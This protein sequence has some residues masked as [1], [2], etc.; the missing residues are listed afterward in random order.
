MA[1]PPNLT[2]SQVPTAGQWNSYFSTKQDALGY[3]PVNRAGDTMF[4]KLNILAS[5]TANAG[6]NLAS[7]TPPNSPIDG[8]L[9]TTNTGLFAQIAGNTIGPIRNG[10]V[11]GPNVAVA[12]NIA[13]FADVTGGVIKDSGTSVSALVPTSRQLTAGTGLTGGGSLASD[14]TVGLSSASVASLALAD[15]SLQPS[16]IGT[17]IATAAQ[18]VKADT[19][20]QKAANL[21][22]IASPQAALLNLGIGSYPVKN[23][24]TIIVGDNSAVINAAIVAANAAGGGDVILPPGTTQATAITLLGN[25]NLVPSGGGSTLLNIGTATYF[26]S[27]QGSLGSPVSLTVDAAA[28]AMTLTMASTTGFSVGDYVLLSD[29]YSYA[30]TDANYKSGET[31]QISAV[32]SSTVL[33]L[34]G[35]IY[36]SM[37]PGNA[38]TVANSAVIQRI[39]PVVAPSIHDVQFYGDKT[40]TST[41]MQFAYA[42]NSTVSVRVQ[43]YGNTAVLM[44]GAISS[45]VIGCFV[46]DLVDDIANGHAGYAICSGG[47]TLGLRVQNNTMSRCRHGFTTIG[48]VT[49]YSHDVLVN[50]NQTRD[51]TQAGIDTH[52]AGDDIL[53]STNDICRS[54]GSGINVRSRRTRVQSNDIRYVAAHGL[55][56]AETGVEG[57]S[58]VDN[59]VANAGQHGLFG[60]VSCLNLDASNNRFVSIGADG[61][62][63]FDS[64]TVDSTGLTLIS[65]RFEGYGTVT[66]NSYGI[67]TTGSVTTTGAVISGNLVMPMSGSASYGIRTLALTG[68]AVVNNSAS[69]TF[70]TLA[71]DLGTN[72]NLNNQRVD[73]SVSQVQLDPTTSAIRAVGSA[74]NIDLLLFAKGTGVLRAGYASAAATTPANFSASRSLQIKDSTGTVYYVPLS[75]A[76]W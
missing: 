42:L 28:A 41:A 60:S 65:N 11:S 2:Y 62:H 58:Y 57:L 49:G 4:G 59:Q 21:G 40:S 19:A 38:Y 35:Q 46:D 68:S 14:V 6:I 69:G 7:G 45:Q 26:L 66:S 71:Y 10:N 9:W 25:V 53:I 31:V 51:T 37:A 12:N 34:V 23:Y 47:P 50:G 36:G 8:D 70:A 29:N 74:T 3:V 39:S 56:F 32:T 30:A 61:I 27:A 13:T 24:G 44:R 55:Q 54:G 5:S 64:G 73:N 17:T 15:N 22:D 72:V 33:T 67:V 43:N 1:G 16:D 75:T 63:L 20:A 52:N 76:T 18:G 48:G